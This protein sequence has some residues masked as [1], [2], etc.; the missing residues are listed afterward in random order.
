MI[1]S[2]F[3]EAP[4][5][6]SHDELASSSRRTF[7]DR[8]SALN[9]DWE[10]LSAP[11]LGA[12]SS[13]RNGRPTDPAVYYKAFLV[14]YFEG[15]ECDTELSD[16]LSDSLSI[17]RFL[18]GSMSGAPPDHSSL[19]RVRKRIARWGDLENLLDP[20]VRLLKEAGLVGG[21]AAALDTTLIPSRARRPHGKDGASGSYDSEAEVAKKP[22][23]QARPSYKVACSADYKHR[24]AVAIDAMPASVGEGACARMA[25][26]QTVRTLGESPSYAVADK[27]MDDSCFHGHAEMYGIQPATPLQANGGKGSSGY[28]KDR[29]RHDPDRDAYVCPAG[30]LLARTSG[31]LAERIRYRIPLSACA[32]CSLRTECHGGRKSAKG[33][34]R[35]YQEGA[36]D[37]VAAR[38]RDPLVKKLLRRRKAVVEPVFSSCKEQGG[39]GKIWTKG[40]GSARVKAK[41]AAIGWNLKILVAK[42]ESPKPAKRRS[43]PDLMAGGALQRR[44][45]ARPNTLKEAW[46]ALI[47][48][49]APIFRSA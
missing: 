48:P 16:R 1:R 23:Y 17:R 37:R 13:E 22:G 34:S 30:R 38:L 7:Y 25:L 14:G 41:F 39:L 2:A 15:I 45:K 5:F 36:R 18:F 31:P 27:G 9:L 19:S 21:E 29:F 33:L 44:I 3:G 43:D 26:T 28:G 47:N 49:I 10:A 42:T 24:A 4:L 11:I 40:L 12:F 35:S 20:A 46:A 8:L 6:Y 32:G